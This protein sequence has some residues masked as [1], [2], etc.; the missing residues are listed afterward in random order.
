MVFVTKLRDRFILEVVFACI[1]PLLLLQVVIAI[2]Y[3]IEVYYST[4][5]SRTDISLK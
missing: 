4:K 2:I 5:Q 3:E 1:L